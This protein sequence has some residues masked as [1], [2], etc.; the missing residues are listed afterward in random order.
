MNVYEG[1]QASRLAKDEK[2]PLES[3]GVYESNGEWEYWYSDSF[4]FD[5][6]TTETREDALRRA[7]L[8]TPNK[9]QKE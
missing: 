5:C 1:A 8:N 3:I 7:L 4:V 9:R 6:G 2:V